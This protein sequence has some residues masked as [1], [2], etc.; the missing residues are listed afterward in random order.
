MQTKLKGGNAFVRLLL[1]H[2]EKIGMAGI[3]VCTAMLLWSAIGRERLGDDQDPEDLQQLITRADTH[4][5][6]FRWETADTER[7]LH[8]SLVSSEA[9]KPIPRSQFPPYAQGLSRRVLDPIGLRTDPI[10]LTAE[11]LEVHGDSGLWAFADAKII[12]RKR[13]EKAAADARLKREREAKRQQGLDEPEKGKPGIRS[14]RGGGLFGANAG[15]VGR[16]TK[17]TKGGA[18]VRS[19][20]IG[21]QLQG[22]EQVKADSWVTLLAKVPIER[23]N[24][25]Y[26][27]ALLSARGYAPLRD[28][29][30][31]PGYQVQRAEVT[32][33]GQGDWA[34]V[35]TVSG[36]TIKRELDTYPVSVPEVIDPRYEHSVLTHPL[37]PLILREWDERASHSSMPLFS[38]FPEQGTGLMEE[39][40]AGEAAEEDDIF[41]NSVSSNRGGGRPSTRRPVPSRL[42]LPRGGGS[43]GEI[44]ARPIGTDLPA[45]VW[46]GT[47]PYVLLRYFDNSAKAGRK[48]RYRVRLVLYDVNSGLSS[49]KNLDE[50]VKARRAK[51]KKNALKYRFTDWSEPSP[52]ASVPLPARI[53]LV[54]AKPAKETN[55]NAEPEVELLIKALNS[56]YAAEIARAEFFARGNVI[57]IHDKATVI[58]ANKFSPDKEP[59]FDF[60]TGVTLLDLR[61]GEKLS[62]RNRDLTVPTRAVLMDAAGRLFVQ[63]ELEDM[64]PVAE[65]QQ[66]LEGDQ[67]SRSVPIGSGSLGR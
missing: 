63:T 57:N 4:I 44:S 13:L 16:S 67:D 48:Y 26:A 29:P 24:Q 61:G 32:D 53:Y 64:E 45:F 9:M 41:S 59:E 12:E 3:A 27:D 2:G 42:T 23:Q 62:N 34:V 35:E 1:A 18:I 19:S 38:E 21:A 56:E 30:V 25:L 39:E 65:Y 15:V 66:A 33:A 54:S 60:R 17:A 37:P 10:L 8:A 14:P 22:F 43:R 11:D 7:T 55:Y 36:R 50:T 58:W 28:I 47:T 46:D 31:Y 49:D 20:R 51:L 6:G 52:V 40:A 5:K